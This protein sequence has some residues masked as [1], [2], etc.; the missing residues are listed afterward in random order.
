M[1][2]KS[3]EELF[4]KMVEE[5][6]VEIDKGLSIEEMQAMYFDENALIEA[7]E[8]VFRI[9]TNGNRY[10]YTFNEDGE[11]QFFTSVTTFIKQTLPTSPQLI[12]WIA[13]MGYEESQAYA[14]ER[15]SYGT[16]MHIQFADFLINKTYDLD[17][18]KGKLK[19]YIDN[20]KLPSSFIPHSDELKKDMLA[21]AKFCHDT[22][23]KPL[24]IELVLTHPTDGYAGAIDLV[25]ELT[26]E[27]SGFFGEV[28]K[29]GKKKGQPRKTKKVD[30]VKA[31]IDFK[32]GRKGFYESSQIQLGAYREMW[33]KRHPETEIHH[34]FNF[35]PKEWRTAPSYTCTDQTESKSLAKL[36]HLVELAAIENADKDQIVTACSGVINF[37]E[38]IENNVDEILL[39]E[40]VKS[41]KRQK[42]T[43]KTKENVAEAVQDDSKAIKEEKQPIPP[44]TQ[45]KPT[46]AKKSAK[47]LG[48]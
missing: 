34:I 3:S 14:A 16:F 18:L 33:N 5:S 48:I 42:D 29:S 15:A 23:L 41:R 11:P 32:S 24:A 1:K 4:D 25:C 12:K 28:F 7:P 6:K 40:W 27:T 17:K 30:R 38:A 39:S 2:S 13:D 47:D 20:E 19:E 35:A 45:K 8:R 31:I 10:Y 21:F 26:A 44:K 9:N 36:P 46:E 37:G 43:P 22:E